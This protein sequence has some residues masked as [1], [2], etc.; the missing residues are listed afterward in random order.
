VGGYSE[1]IRHAPDFDLWLRMSWQFPFVSSRLVT[2]NYR[3]HGSQIS[4]AAPHSQWLSVYRSRLAMIDRLRACGQSDVARQLES[5]L[6]RCWE[7][8]LTRSLRARRLADLQFYGSLSPMLPRKTATG[9]LVCRL[10]A[11][12]DSLISAEGRLPAPVRKFVRH[13]L[14]RLRKNEGLTGDAA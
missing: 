2:A 7:H 11:L 5:L 4:A 3:W 13:S 12:T 1:S 14:A 6:A 8:D 9:R 10:A